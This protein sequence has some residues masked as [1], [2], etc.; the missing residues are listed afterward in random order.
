MNDF[1]KVDYVHKT[2]GVN[3]SLRVGWLG[4]VERRDERTLLG[5]RHKRNAGLGRNGRR[6]RKNDN[7]GL[8][9]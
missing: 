1:S 4:Y 8:E 3:K 2:I 6:T 5:M 9:K 7:Q